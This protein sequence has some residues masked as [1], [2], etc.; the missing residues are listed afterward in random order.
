MN[1]STL[2]SFL[3]SA[4]IALFAPSIGAQ[5]IYPTAEAAAD[6]FVDA[7]AIS[8]TS[9]LGKVLGA[10]WRRFVPA[11]GIGR[12]DINKFLAAW[13][14]SHRVSTP[15]PDRAALE[16]GDEHWALPIPIVKRATGWQF[17]PKA[18][19]DEMRTRRI[20]RNELAAMQAVLA[21]FDAQKDYARIDRDGDGVL[22]YAQKFGS[23]RGKHD[24]LYWETKSGEAQSPLGPRFMPA[25]PGDGY[26]GYRYK[27]LNAQGKDAPGGAY[28]YRIKGRMTSGFAIVAWP[29]R[30]GDTGVMSL[31]LNHDGQLYEKDLGPNS[32]KIAGS[33]TSFNPDS[34]WKKVAAPV[35]SPT[36]P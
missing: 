35:A 3:A 5:Q 20:G 33:M 15:S 27:I 21:Y 8:D 12:D 11:E 28:D 7:L 2:L 32:A 9:A 10:D 14:K 18:G 25:K 16:V 34:S 1:R 31:M 4:S 36:T 17:D 24:G 19:V 23:A 22:Q 6:A 26:H 29:I 13:A 30:Y